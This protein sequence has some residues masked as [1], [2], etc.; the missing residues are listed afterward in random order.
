MDEMPEVYRPPSPDPLIDLRVLVLEL[1]GEFA[2]T[3]ELV[4]G[5]IHM[6]FQKRTPGMLDYLKQRR[7]ISKI[8]DD[9]RPMLTLTLAEELQ[10]VADLTN[11]STVYKRVKRVRDY[12]GHS[13]RIDVIGPD[14][15]Q[16]TKQFLTGFGEKPAPPMVVTRDELIARICDARWLAQ[17]VQFILA[18]GGLTKMIYLGDRKIEFIEPPATPESWDGTQFAFVSS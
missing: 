18:T 9:D 11:F 6:Y 14:T 10:T 7:D 4:D 12:A 1:V 13:S 17:H 2:R 5:L 3:Q 16:L 8:V 15:L